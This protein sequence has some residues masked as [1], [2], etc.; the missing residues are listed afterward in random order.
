MTPVLNR[1][2][3]LR[4]MG[5]ADLYLLAAEYPSATGMSGYSEMA[6]LQH[7]EICSAI[8]GELLYRGLSPL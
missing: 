2:A 7:A 4:S 6:L 1:M 3:Q 5:D 8:K